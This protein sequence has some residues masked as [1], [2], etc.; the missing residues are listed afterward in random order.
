M[1][2][3]LYVQQN[4]TCRWENTS[5]NELKCKVGMLIAMGLH[6]LPD[7]RLY[8]STDPFFWV[9]PISDMMKQSRFKKLKEALHKND[10]SNA[11][12][13]SDTNFDKLYKVRPQRK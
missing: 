13:R 4:K 5:A 1:Q 6:P 7:S 9:Q 10:N 2:T 11:P 12:K 8:W 3:N